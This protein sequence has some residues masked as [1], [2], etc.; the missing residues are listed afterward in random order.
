ML[1]VI[2]VTITAMASGTLAAL[3]MQHIIP[4][5]TNGAGLWLRPGAIVRKRRQQA[6]PAK[7]PTTMPGLN[8]PPEPPLPTVKAVAASF[9]T[10]MSRTN[11]SGKV[12]IP[13]LSARWAQ[14][15]P[16]LSTPGTPMARAPVSTPPSAG[17]ATTAHRVEPRCRPAWRAQAMALMYSRPSPAATRPTTRNQT[18]FSGC[19]NT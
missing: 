5:M 1:E 4:M 7:A 15:S 13:R 9:A 2:S 12:R 3:P 18:R 19:R 17:R 6:A 14:P 8:K 10:G 16:A 11:H